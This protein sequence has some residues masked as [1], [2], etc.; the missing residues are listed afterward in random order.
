MLQRHTTAYAALIRGEIAAV[1][2]RSAEMVEAYR[3]AQKR[4]D[5][6][7]GRFL[8]GRAYVETGHFAEALAELEIAAKRH[9]ETTDAFFTDHQTLRYLP[10]MY[11]WLGRAQEGLGAIGS[12]RTRYEEYVKLRPEADPGDALM[13]DA[14]ERLRRL[15]AAP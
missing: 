5:S 9:G 4:H 10:P 12:A 8:L 7:F 6:W 1:Q 3:D 11:Y 13:A 14:R 2:K 15:S